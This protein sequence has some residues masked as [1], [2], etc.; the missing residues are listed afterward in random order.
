[1]DKL[2]LSLLRYSCVLNG[3]ASKFS[4]ILDLR[5]LRKLAHCD[6]NSESVRVGWFFF[7]F[8]TKSSDCLHNQ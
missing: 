4:C 2:Q 7:F 8:F 3:C 1:M 5:N 6:V